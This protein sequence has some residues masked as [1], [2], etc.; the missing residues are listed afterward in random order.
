MN[1]R[2]A[3]GTDKTLSS[4]EFSVVIDVN[5]VRLLNEKPFLRRQEFVDRSYVID[6]QAISDR[7]STRLNSSHGYLSSAVFCLK[8]NNK[9]DPSADSALPA[10][11]DDCYGAPHGCR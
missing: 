8:K 10:V 5:I 7:K 3:V 11:V 4:Q 2:S 6:A 9:R 1:F